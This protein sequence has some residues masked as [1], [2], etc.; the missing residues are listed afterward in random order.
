MSA[1]A[2]L[3]ARPKEQDK[4]TSSEVKLPF[5]YLY[6][7]SGWLSPNVKRWLGGNADVAPVI[8]SV[9]EQVID[10]TSTGGISLDPSD[11]LELL[12][13]FRDGMNVRAFLD[14]YPF[15]VSL[16]LEASPKINKYFPD[17]ELALQVIIDPEAE[18]DKQLMV[19]IIET[20]S[21]DDVYEQLERFDN[22]WWIGAVN[23]AKG[24]LCI[25]VEF[26]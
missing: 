18:K 26:V 11:F 23:R 16:L 4:E 24:K 22:E 13:T 19:L 25:D 15:L 10:V 9:Q 8:D 21:P 17:K 3:T 6:K 2:A 14:R 5:S 12:Y 7:V 1:N 20:S